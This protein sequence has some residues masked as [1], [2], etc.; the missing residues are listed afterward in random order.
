V[1]EGAHVVPAAARDLGYTFAFPELPSALDDL[2][3]NRDDADGHN[4]PLNQLL[5]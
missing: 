5:G 2:L 3:G 4:N 1:L